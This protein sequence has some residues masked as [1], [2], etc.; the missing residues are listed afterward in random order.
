MPRIVNNTYLN[1]DF[2]NRKK[3]NTDMGVV[4][5]ELKSR[6]EIMNKYIQLFDYQRNMQLQQIEEENA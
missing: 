1:T 6:Y 2:K 3:N 5:A 4:F